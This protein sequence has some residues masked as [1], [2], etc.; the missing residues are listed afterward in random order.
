MNRGPSNFGYCRIV[1]QIV[2][3]WFVQGNSPLISQPA[4]QQKRFE[5]PVELWNVSNNRKFEEFEVIWSSQQIKNPIFGLQFEQGKRKYLHSKPEVVSQISRR[6]G[7]Q[8]LIFVDNRP[9]CVDHLTK[10][11]WR[12]SLWK[13]VVFLDFWSGR[14]GLTSWASWTVANCYQQKVW[15]ASSAKFWRPRPWIFLDV[16]FF[17]W[18]A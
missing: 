13:S 5:A 12:K 18:T 14:S 9:Q 3:N 1:G 11:A 15:C 10:E 2:F 7:I 8:R 4:A 17:F 16:G 6:S